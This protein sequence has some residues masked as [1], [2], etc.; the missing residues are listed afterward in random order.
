MTVDTGNY[1]DFFEFRLD[2]EK[3]QLLKNGQTVQLTPKAFQILLLLVQNSGQTT[4]KED[5]FNQLWAD[6][7]VEEANL[8]QHIYVLRKV[9]GETP[10]GQSYI[11]T[12]PKQGYRF[13]LLPEQISIQ[14]ELFNQE[15]ISSDS[16]IGGL[17]IDKNGSSSII[18]KTSRL[19]RSK[20]PKPGRLS[21]WHYFLSL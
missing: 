18:D 20:D 5:I 19:F 17:T 12:V 14:K 7:F 9:L 2:I 10:S 15:H 16:N 3:Q 8:T 6:S 4:K 21:R 1:Y 13:T 11:E